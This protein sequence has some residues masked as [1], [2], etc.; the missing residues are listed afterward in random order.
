MCRG[1]A[2]GVGAIIVLQGWGGSEAGETEAASEVEM[3]TSRVCPVAVRVVV[4]VASGVA[5]IK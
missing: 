4:A 1:A 5:A 3:R 2:S